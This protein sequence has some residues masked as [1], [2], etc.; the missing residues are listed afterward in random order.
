MT[1]HYIDQPVI[2]GARDLWVPG[3]PEPAYGCVWSV[4]E[5]GDKAWHVALPNTEANPSS[6]LLYVPTGPE[7]TSC[8]IEC[9]YKPGHELA[10]PC[11][12]CGG[13]GC[14]GDNG[15]DGCK[16]EGMYRCR[17]ISC[18]HMRLFDAVDSD[19]L[20]AGFGGIVETGEPYHWLVCTLTARDNL[21]E[22]AWYWVIQ[23]E[24]IEEQ[25]Q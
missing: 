20:W 14:V 12:S 3:L 17:V 11:P 5:N 7:D 24:P 22:T 9:P 16:A 19:G 2:P 10:L 4:N 6:E 1:T 8:F 18:R 13:V 15:C 25:A 21:P 23:T